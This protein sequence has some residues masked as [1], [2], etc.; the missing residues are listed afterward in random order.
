[1]HFIRDCGVSSVLE[2]SCITYTLRF[3]ALASCVA[4]SPA[5]MQSCARDFLALMKKSLFLETP[6]NNYHETTN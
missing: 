1:M 5:S 4:L 6:L 2:P 3:S